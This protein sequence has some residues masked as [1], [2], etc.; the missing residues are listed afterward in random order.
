[1]LPYTDTGPK[2]A[3]IINYYY[4]SQLV[5]F[6]IC[7]YPCPWIYCV[8]ALYVTHFMVRFEVASPQLGTGGQASSAAPRL[9][10][11]FEWT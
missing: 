8:C 1:M 7:F 11:G 10:F 2:G 9:R 4:L 6:R 5:C 3:F